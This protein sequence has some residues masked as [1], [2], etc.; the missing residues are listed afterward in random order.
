MMK[1]VLNT[2]EMNTGVADSNGA[3]WY[4][5]GIEGWDAPSLRQ[6]QIEPSSR[7][8]NVPTV[9]LLGARALVLTGV[10]KTTGGEAGFWKAYNRL[11]GETAHLATPVPLIGTED[12]DKVCMVLRAG[13][14]KTTIKPGSFE[15]EVPLTAPDPLKYA[16]TST[17]VSIAPGQ[18]KTLV[19]AGTF[20]SDRITALN[21]SQGTTRLTHVGTGRYVATDTVPI[22]SAFDYQTRTVMGNSINQYGQ[23]AS[24]SIWWALQPG[25]NQIRNDGAVAMSLNFYS[26]WV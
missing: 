13:T 16:T 15:F 17:T 4:M 24:S 14:P 9:N 6:G 11:Q 12:V 2:I 5:T 23:V 18:T 19:N 26:A 21:T 3:L 7:H 25:S 22:N 20:D 10:C 8:G 1:M